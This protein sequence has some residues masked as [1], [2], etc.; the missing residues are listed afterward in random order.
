MFCRPASPPS[1]SAEHPILPLS[2]SPAISPVFSQLGS[3][4]PPLF[5][6]PFFSSRAHVRLLLRCFN[7]SSF[8][9]TGLRPSL[10]TAACSRACGLNVYF[11]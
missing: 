7:T 11:P 5:D 4:L 9:C 10:S 1:A 2:H 8:N 6:R 3:S